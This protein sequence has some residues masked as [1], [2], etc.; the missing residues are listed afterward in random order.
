MSFSGKAV[1]FGEVELDQEF[2]NRFFPANEGYD[3]GSWK[4]GGFT[5]RIPLRNS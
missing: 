2:A 3:V 5:L 1:V 4:V